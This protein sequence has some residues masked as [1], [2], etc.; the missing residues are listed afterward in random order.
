VIAI[1]LSVIVSVGI[2][3]GVAYGTNTPAEAAPQDI[4]VP[5]V[6]IVLPT[7]ITLPGVTVTRL[8]TLAPVTVRPPAVT[9]R[10]TPAPVTIIPPPVVR[11][12]LVPRTVTLPGPVRTVQRPGLPGATTTAT[13]V[14]SREVISNG[15]APPV[16]REVRSTVPGGQTTVTSATVAPP[17]KEVIRIPGTT[18]TV[19]K[20]QAVG[21]SLLALLAL[22]GLGIFLLWLGFVLGY[23]SSEK[24]NNNFLRAL[25]DTIR[26]RP[27]KHM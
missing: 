7:T 16:T 26:R 24:E 13:V 3:F 12:I 15:T 18:K 10:V 14:V 11:T 27:G 22:M 6:C 21:L 5:P 1:L 4:C 17:R 20:I 2:V 25:R 23:K 9:V 19:T 8:I